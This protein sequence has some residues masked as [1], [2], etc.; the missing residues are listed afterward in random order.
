MQTAADNDRS[1]TVIVKNRIRRI[2]NVD[3]PVG[4][5]H[6][7]SM[8]NGDRRLNG[9]KLVVESDTFVKL[10]RNVSIHELT[11]AGSNVNRGVYTADQL[12]EIVGKSIF[13]G[14]GV[15]TVGGGSGFVVTIR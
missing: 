15:L 8:L 5:T 4:A 9:V 10:T 13:S 2:D 14:S 3:V 6:F 1:G 11:I 7:P 12:N